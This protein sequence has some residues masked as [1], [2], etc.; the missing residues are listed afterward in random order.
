MTDCSLHRPLHPLP[1]R[2]IVLLMLALTLCTKD[3]VPATQTPAVTSKTERG[4]CGKN[5]KAFTLAKKRLFS[6]LLSANN[7]IQE[8]ILNTINCCK[9]TNAILFCLLLTQHR[10]IHKNQKGNEG[11]NKTNNF[12]HTQQHSLCYHNMKNGDKK[13]G[14]TV[15]MVA[16]TSST[17]TRDEE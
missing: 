13:V 10:L 12:T 5:K 4:A 9:K 11:L 14:N 7:V 6:L 17:T 1:L 3:Y 16:G 8:S 2:R 15:F